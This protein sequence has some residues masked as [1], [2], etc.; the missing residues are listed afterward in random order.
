MSQKL[1]LTNVVEDV[2][3]GIPYPAIQFD[4]G[5]APLYAGN[6]EIIGSKQGYSLL[7]WLHDGNDY[8][9]LHSGSDNIVN[10]NRGD[11][12]I[13]L[14][15]SYIDAQPGGQV[16]AGKGRDTINIIGGWFPSS[17]GEFVNGNNDSDVINN[18]A[19][20]AGRVRGGKG[21]DF[22][23]NYKG[24]MNAY[25]DR[26]SDTFVPFYDFSWEQSTWMGIK[27]FQVGYDILDTSRLGSQV[28]QWIGD[29]GLDIF[30]DGDYGTQVVATL[31][32]VY[33]YI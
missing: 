33:Q 28:T 21:N 7:A 23:Y 2:F 9:E 17:E 31:E 30:V 3:A 13:N 22:F 25:G 16:S 6:D 29:R 26:G 19:P 12:T 20:N 14:Y 11:D 27:D 5:I 24:Y 10:T 1:N 18:W 8:L 4:P 32:G 15:S